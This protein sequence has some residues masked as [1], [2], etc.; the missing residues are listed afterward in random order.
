ME[1]RQESPFY[2]WRCP[3]GTQTCSKD[4]AELSPAQGQIMG[5]KGLVQAPCPPALLPPL[6]P[7]SHLKGDISRYSR[8]CQHDSCGNR[9]AQQVS[10]LR[11]WGWGQA[12][13]PTGHWS[14]VQTPST[15]PGA[16]GTSQRCGH[17]GFV[18]NSPQGPQG[19]HGT[20][21]GGPRTQLPAGRGRHQ[22]HCLRSRHPGAAL[23]CYSNM[24]PLDSIPLN[25]E[26]LVSG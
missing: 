18:G 2:V 23:R 6:S 14:L 19:W 25:G 26:R 12:T 4:R 22:P 17:H 3:P 15:K 20:L 9:G 8:G 5:C 11:H 16:L 13:C 7:Q 24:K 10:E 1:G 21:L